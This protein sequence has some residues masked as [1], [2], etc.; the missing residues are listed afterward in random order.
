[1]NIDEYQRNTNATA[2]YPGLLEAQGLPYVLLGLIG[3]V[4][5][6]VSEL[7]HGLLPNQP[8][9]GGPDTFFAVLQA[10]SDIGV[11][12]EQ[13]KKAIRDDGGTL[14]GER[15]RKARLALTGLKMTIDHLDSDFRRGVDCVEL[16]TPT[17]SIDGDE[18]P[19]IRKELGDICWYLA[20]THENL[21]IKWSDTLKANNDKLMSR[22]ERNVLSGDG[23][24]R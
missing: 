7:E 8:E 1:M 5:E 20:Q 14:K 16:D 9:Y 11:I 4:G 13:L 6:T 18:I 3:E 24:A 17:V 10:A 19:T 12:A 23:G 22:L 15:L 21:G 2:I